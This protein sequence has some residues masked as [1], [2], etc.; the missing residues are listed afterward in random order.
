MTP[1]TCKMVATSDKEL[2]KIIYILRTSR[3]VWRKLPSS[4]IDNEQRW[5]LLK[6]Y[7]LMMINDHQDMKSITLLLNLAHPV[8]SHSPPKVAIG[9]PG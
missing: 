7:R 4:R 8:T 3:K 5:I 6:A 2:V 9:R 1:M